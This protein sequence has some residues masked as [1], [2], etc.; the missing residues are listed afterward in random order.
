LGINDGKRLGLTDYQA[1]GNPDVDPEYI[2]PGADFAGH[3]AAA[4]N[5]IAV[6]LVLELQGCLELCVL[7]SGFFKLGHLVAQGG[8]L[9]PERFVFTADPGTLEHG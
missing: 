5:F 8:I 6:V 7:A 2:K 1:I 9:K 4:N 3:Q